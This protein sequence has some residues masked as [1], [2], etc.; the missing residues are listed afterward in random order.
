[1]DFLLLVVYRHPG[2]VDPVQVPEGALPHRRVDVPLADLS[3]PT[4]DLPPIYTETPRWF[5]FWH[6]YLELRRTLDA[7]TA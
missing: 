4:G 3:I 7:R 2:N 1:M 5:I 6:G